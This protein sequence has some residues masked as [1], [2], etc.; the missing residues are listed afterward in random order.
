MTFAQTATATALSESIQEKVFFYNSILNGLYLLIRPALALA[1][2]AL[3]NSMIYGS[4]LGLDAPLFLIWNIIK[5]IANFTLWFMVLFEILKN[6]FTTGEQGKKAFDVIKKALIAWVLIQSSWFL[7]GAMIDV[8]TIATYSIGGMPLHILDN[9]NQCKDIGTMKMLPV[10]SRVNFTAENQSNNSIDNSFVYYYYVNNA[11]GESKSYFSPCEL[12]DGKRVVGQKYR[13]GAGWIPY[14]TDGYCIL[15]NNMFAYFSGGQIAANSDVLDEIN[16]SLNDQNALS[17]VTDDANAHIHYSNNLTEIATLSGWWLNDPEVRTERADD[18]L[19]F[20]VH[21]TIISDPTNDGPW[22]HLLNKGP[23]SAI[24]VFDQA[25]ELKDLID[26]AEW[27]VGVLITLYKSILNFVSFNTGSSSVDTFVMFLEAL[28]KIAF[29]IALLVPLIILAA[30]LLIRIGYIWMFIALSPI[31][32]LKIAFT[33]E[34]SIKGL[35]SKIPLLKDGIG[36][37]LRM[38][39]APVIITFALSFS[40]VFMTALITSI[41]NTENNPSQC[42]WTQ[43]Q[44][45]E[46]MNVTLTTWDDTRTYQIAGIAEVSQSAFGLNVTGAQ[47]DIFGWILINLFGAAIV[48]L[49]LLVVIETVFKW[50]PVEKWNLSKTAGNMLASVPIIPVP[51]GAGGWT[52]IGAGTAASLVEA[53]SSDIARDLNPRTQADDIL[54][55]NK[56][57]DDDNKKSASSTTNNT[58]DTNTIIETIKNDDTKRNAVIG[59]AVASGL[60]SQ[61]LSNI[62]AI[63]DHKDDITKE[64]LS[65][66]IVLNKDMYEQYKKEIEWI[67]DVDEKLKTIEQAAKWIEDNK[68]SFSKDEFKTIL[69]R[70]DDPLSTY[71]LPTANDQVIKLGD[72]SYK[73]TFD[74]TNWNY[75]FIVDT[76]QTAE[77]YDMHRKIDETPDYTLPSNTTPTNP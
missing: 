65:K 63:K 67:T 18:D 1:W 37:V 42:M 45:Y 54:N 75:D 48:W 50:T 71:L 55:R 64:E 22:I 31:I 29:G 52:G 40:L 51:D 11:D 20:N 9:D 60:G 43:T 36:S 30:A 19:I 12:Y 26:K 58:T 23:N 41:N 13:S 21:G 16:A 5:N 56:K 10:G 24:T 7:M 53:K 14:N 74:E 28:L 4:F 35:W 39:F 34:S 38:V 8:S 2:F 32:A 6:F 73:M 17:P 76:A 46:S 57:N 68:S 70:K 15:P 49:L 66:Q 69:N 44:F 27:Y 59:A 25:P 61:D 33:D 77:T 62:E 72:V 47:K 3:D